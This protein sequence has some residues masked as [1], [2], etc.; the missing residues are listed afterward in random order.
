[1]FKINYRKN[2]RKLFFGITD[3][4]EIK[5]L[6]IITNLWEKKRFNFCLNRKL[7]RFFDELFDKR[8]RKKT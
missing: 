6:K 7:K 8:V 3:K 5:I 2:R 1:M 4:K